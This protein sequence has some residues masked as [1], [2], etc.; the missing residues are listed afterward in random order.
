MRTYPLPGSLLG[1]FP[2]FF[3]AS[4]ITSGCATTVER[5]RTEDAARLLAPLPACLMQLSSRGGKAGSSGVA[6]ALR[7]EQY[8]KLVYPGFDATRSALPANARTCT[9]TSVLDDPSLAGGE[10]LHA[11]VEEGDA[12][13][14]GG[15]D[16]L[17]IIWLRSS[18]FEDGTMGGTLALVR[19]YEASA[20]V[21]AVGPFRGRPTKS[22]FS[23]ERI[24][25]EV[26]VVAQDDG[27]TGRAPGAACETSLSV[28]LP[29][30]GSLRRIATTAIE[31][32]AYLENSE[33][34]VHGRVEYRLAST[35]QFF[36]GG[37][38][39]LEQVVVRDSLGRVIR[40]AELDRSYALMPDDS[41]VV[42][43]ESI[44]SRL[45][46]PTKPAEKNE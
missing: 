12:V 19:G 40:E 43:D 20:E 10:P 45:I 35:P 32:V 14:A 36:T 21:Y 38:R 31:R 28:L 29:R 13:I 41:M 27:C 9:G 7:E 22:R 24:G 39:V 42:S 8:W 3:C 4:L 34:G 15:S 46:R 25:A 1:L 26:V 44:W 16:R 37:I 18:R 17:R 2:L 33:P 5:P 23:L 6:V 30:Q 11:K